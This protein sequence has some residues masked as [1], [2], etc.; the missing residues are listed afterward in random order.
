MPNRILRDGILTSPRVNELTWESE[1]FYRRLMSVVDD[2]GR[3]PAHPAILRAALYP[4]KLDTVRETTIERLIAECVK[5]RLVCLYEVSS[6]QYLEIQDFKQRTRVTKYPGPEQ[7]TPCAHGARTMRAESP[8]SAR[9]VGGEGGGVFEGEGE[10]GNGASAPEWVA[11][12]PSNLKTD[13]FIRTW[14]TYLKY[15]KEQ[16][17]KVLA[18]TGTKQVFSKLSGWGERSAIE[19]IHHSMSNSWTGIFQPSG[20]GSAAPSKTRTVALKDDEQ[21]PVYQP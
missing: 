17:V 1:V 15:R 20:N 12:L 5:V 8:R 13:E 10:G 3:F 9:L 4:L 21:P 11:W 18:E 14:T 16:R 2:F 7:G 19:A 6:K